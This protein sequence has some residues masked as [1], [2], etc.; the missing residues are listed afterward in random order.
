M[1]PCGAR[2]GAIIVAAGVAEPPTARLRAAPLDLLKLAR[3]AGP[4]GM[5]ATH[6]EVTGDLHVA[7]G[8]ATLLKLARPD[9]E[10]EL[11]HWV[12]DV[13]ARELGLAAAGAVAWLKRAGAA[14]EM[15]TAEF[16]QDERR[17][18]PAELEAQG[19]YADVERLR[20]DV[21]RAAARLKQ[22]EQRR[23]AACAA[24]D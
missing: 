21:E 5:R 22:L 23:A 6:A 17:A 19:F 12:G 15:N 9:L 3:S 10:E 18:L 24:S 8:F 7:E 16:L 2:R 20:D 11:S 14:L 1:R 4:G 13:A